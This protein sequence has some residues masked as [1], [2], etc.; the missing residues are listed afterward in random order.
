MSEHALLASPLDHGDR[1]RIEDLA[2]SLAH[3]V[4][5]KGA[6]NPSHC[7][8]V[9]RTARIIAHGLGIRGDA[10]F[11]IHIA[12]LL[13]DVGKLHVP[14]SILLAPRPLTPDERAVIERHPIE[15]HKMLQALGL[16]DEARWVLHHHE[17]GDGAGYP[18]GL[19]GDAIPLGSRIL[20]VADAFDVMCSTR[21]YQLARTPTEAVAE[22]RACQD[23]QFDRTIVD[24]LS[25]ALAAGAALVG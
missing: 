1:D 21:A 15:A 3:A 14:D 17:R 9:A 23:G 24:V 11:R 7:H 13:H 4:D 10:V 12:G 8:G 25:A 22:L 20:L 2:I 6:Y 5:V 19:A 16:R 18:T